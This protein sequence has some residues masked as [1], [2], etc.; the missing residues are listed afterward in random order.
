MIVTGALATADLAWARGDP[1]AVLRALEPVLDI[2]PRQGID[3]PGFWPWPHL[4]ADALISAG[5]LDE[6]ADF[7][8]PHEQLAARAGAAFE[9]RSPGPGAGTTGGGSRADRTRPTTAFEHSLDQLDGLPLPFERALTELAY[10]QMFRRRGHR[11]A[12]ISPAGSR[13]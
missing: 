9:H 2:Q 4:Y 10:G 11:R 13:A 12:A 5:R 3:E 1:G 6:A 7:L 8:A